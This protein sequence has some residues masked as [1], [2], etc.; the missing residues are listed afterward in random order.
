MVGHPYFQERDPH[1][2]DDKPD[3]DAAFMRKVRERIADL[4][5]AGPPPPPAPCAAHCR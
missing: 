1:Y 4:G 2:R 5:L 3:P